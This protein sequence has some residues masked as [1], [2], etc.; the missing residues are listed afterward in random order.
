MYVVTCCRWHV[1]WHCV[2]KYPPLRY[3]WICLQFNNVAYWMCE[4]FWYDVTYSNGVKIYVNHWINDDNNVLKTVLLLAVITCQLMLHIA[5]VN[6]VFVLAF[7]SL[8][9][10]VSSSQ[11]IMCV[12]WLTVEAECLLSRQLAASVIACCFLGLFPRCSNCP[13][14]FDELLTNMDRW[15][16]CNAT[17]I[18]SLQI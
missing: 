8:M 4:T 14:N 3:L 17:V 16:V 11:Y 1:Q 6:V 13:V 7:V 5:I 18:F 10:A 9:I 15:S 12:C 2:R